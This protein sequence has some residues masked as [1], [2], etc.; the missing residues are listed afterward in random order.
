MAQVTDLNKTPTADLAPNMSV[1]EATRR[2]LYIVN[3]LPNFIAGTPGGATAENQVIEI[4]NLGN[5]SNGVQDI[6]ANLGAAVTPSDASASPF[7]V[8]SYSL[9]EAYNGST[10]DR[11]RA[12]LTTISSTFTGFLNDLPWAVFHTSP[13][14]RTSGQGGPLEA[15]SSGNLRGAEQFAAAAEDNTN[16]V[17]AIQNKPLAAST[18]AYLVDQSAAL[19]A[20]SITKATPGA[21]R[22]FSGR[23]DSTAPS[24]TYYLQ[25][26]NATSLPADGAVTLL[27]AP[28]KIIHTVGS[29]N[30]VILDF[31]MNT[32]FASSGIVWGLSSTEFTKTITAAYVSSTVL[33]V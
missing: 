17:F 28:T 25:F 8:N 7:A 14:T 9:N 10:W 26:Y 12:G 1:D 18:Y 22:L 11:V 19:E 32:V 20:S 15:D 33:Y 3:Q 24:A 31:T 27:C 13:T 29:D 23:I 30:S 21:L 6:D 4:S 5:I 16:G 2:I